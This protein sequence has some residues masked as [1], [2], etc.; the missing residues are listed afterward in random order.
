M[1]IIKYFGPNS[2]AIPKEIEFRTELPKTKLGKVDFKALESEN[3][4]EENIQT[5]KT[6]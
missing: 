4:K 2:E 3:L 6:R 1:I 5:E